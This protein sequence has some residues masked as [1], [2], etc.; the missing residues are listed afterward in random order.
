MAN[1]PRDKVTG[2]GGSA[3]DSID[4]DTPPLQAGTVLGSYTV[5]NPVE[6]G[7]GGMGRV[8]RGHHT[9]LGQNVA[10]KVLDPSLGRTPANR[11]HD[12]FIEEARIMANI[13]H[14]HIVRVMD[15]GE[16]VIEEVRHLF[17][18]MDYLA[19]STLG[20]ALT[21]AS[22]EQ[23]LFPIARA[24]RICAQI[25]DAVQ[26]AYAQGIIHRD[27]KPENIFL[28]PGRD[29]D[30][31]AVLLD[32]GIARRIIEGLEGES[33]L[34][35]AGITLGTPEYLSPEQAIGGALDAKTD[36]YSL[37][38][39]L[40]EA[41]T[42]SLPHRDSAVTTAGQ[43][44]LRRANPGLA[45]KRVTEVRP[46]VPK[47]VADL[48]ERML[49][50]E[51]SDRPTM[52]ECATVLGEQASEV[53]ATAV[54]PAAAPRR[55]TGAVSSPVALAPTVMA[56]QPVAVSSAP[57]RHIPWAA[58]V[59][60]IVAIG[61][62]W[63][64]SLDREAPSPVQAPATEASLQ[65]ED[66]PVVEVAP[67]AQ[68][69]PPAAQAPVAAPAPAQPAQPAAT[70]GGLSRDARELRRASKRAR[71]LGAAQPPAKPA[72]AAPLAPTGPAP[73]PAPAPPDPAPVPQPAAVV[74]PDAAVAS[75]PQPPPPPEPP[76]PEPKPPRAA[77]VRGAKR[78]RPDPNPKLVA[79]VR[80]LKQEL[81]SN[82]RNRA[83]L[84][85]VNSLCQEL[86]DI[87]E[88]K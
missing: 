37:G 81:R 88:C 86:G 44:R 4:E 50:Y 60:G 11:F 54:T 68:A 59:V 30:D 62:V 5:D 14:D 83:L 24:L 72:P 48:L 82:P 41:L 31:H 7:R 63:V 67:P 35:G 61:V 33:R 42:R 65:G 17:L 3:A 27:L 51:A 84:A 16:A 28:T 49:A 23:G 70:R 55:R 18:V 69:Q 6:G 73:P 66:Q 71:N 76:A 26:H 25:A 46:D 78:G 87:P 53:A 57:K 40:Y 85:R 2:R 39:V 20:S 13:R 1:T 8:Y 77:P 38:L 9:T 52:A 21:V 43:I 22:S 36:V 34:T 58:V 45:P 74:Q 75:T 29:G 56:E 19:G 64:L 80:K 15:F 10:I 32:F 47:A 12:R 79:E